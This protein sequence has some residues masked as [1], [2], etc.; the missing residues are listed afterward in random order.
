M[1]LEETIREA[2]RRQAKAGDHAAAEEAERWVLRVSV[3]LDWIAKSP[4]FVESQSEAAALLC[5]FHGS[6]VAA[7]STGG[8]HAPAGQRREERT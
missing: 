4:Q 7:E 6:K 3:L 2:L 8:E 1:T 5:R